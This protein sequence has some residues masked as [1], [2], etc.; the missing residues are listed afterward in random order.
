MTTDQTVVD[1]YEAVLA[2]LHSKR[3]QI[4]QAITVLVALR[5]GSAAPAGP[6][7]GD[8]ATENGIVE[9]AGMYL[10]MSIV[11]AAKKLLNLRKR[12]MANAEILAELKAGGLVLTGADPLNVVSSVLTRRF[13]NVGDVV[14]VARGTWGLK[15]WYPGRNFK[16]TGKLSSVTTGPAPNDTEFVSD[17][18]LDREAS[19]DEIL[20]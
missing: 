2:D 9:T 14:R 5:S 3:E 11:D 10:G 12:T 8:A 1:P 19:N 4:D 16:P 6:R 13:N 17:I 18:G 20:G 7:S 15:D